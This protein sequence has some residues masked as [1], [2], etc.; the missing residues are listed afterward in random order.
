MTNINY[1][2]AK[3]LPY[4]HFFVY[5]QILDLL[6]TLVGLK[7]GVSEASPFVRWLMNW[8]PAA[9]VAV[10]KLVALGLAGICVTINKHHLIRWIT[11]WYAGLIVW[12]L[13]TILAGAHA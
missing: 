5:L 3:A 11:Y 9:G 12:N 8:G 6:T 13:C 7:F 10:S 4:I 2:E 1:G